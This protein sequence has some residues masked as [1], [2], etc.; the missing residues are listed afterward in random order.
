MTG[1]KYSKLS[2]NKK[3]VY[4]DGV[5]T[6]KNGK[7]LRFN[8][9]GY[10][11]DE[12]GLPCTIYNTRILDRFEHLG[13]YEYHQIVA[14]DFYKGD[15]FLVLVDWG[16]SNSCEVYNNYGGYGTRKIIY[17]VL[18]RTVCSGRSKRRRG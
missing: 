9:S 4:I 10:N 8:M 15:C 11:Y 18:E 14:L 5:L 2:E 16:Y 13:V 3:M 17:D 12:D 6:K 7:R 1:E